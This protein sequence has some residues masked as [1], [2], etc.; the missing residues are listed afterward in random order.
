[1][2]NQGGFYEKVV[3]HSHPHRPTDDSRQLASA[4]RD[5]H[6]AI[7]ARRHRNVGHWIRHRSKNRRRRP[8]ADLRHRGQSRYQ[9]LRL[10][11]EVRSQRIQAGASGI[12]FCHQFRRPERSERL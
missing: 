10:R 9:Q 7:A 4:G 11:P 5:S 12:G 8:H 3:A 2:V 1:M 6:R